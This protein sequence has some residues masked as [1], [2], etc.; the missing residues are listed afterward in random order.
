M[1]PNRSRTSYWGSRD[2]RPKLAVL[3]GREASGRARS[4]RE[5]TTSFHDLPQRVPVDV[6]HLSFDGGQL[7]RKGARLL[8]RVSFFARFTWCI[9]NHYERNRYEEDHPRHRPES[10]ALCRQDSHVHHARAYPDPRFRAIHRRS[11]R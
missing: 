4:R 2:E 10:H 7:E 6:V 5:Q 9:M 8:Q 1:A 11:Q 3:R